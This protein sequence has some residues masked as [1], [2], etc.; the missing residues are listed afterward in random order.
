MVV[1]INALNLCYF[2]YYK[3]VPGYVKY[4]NEV[5]SN[6]DNF[7]YQTL[8]SAL[9]ILQEKPR[10]VLFSRL[11]RMEYFYKENRNVPGF[12]VIKDN[13]IR[14]MGFIFTKYSPLTPL[15]LQYGLQNI[16]SGVYDKIASSWLG[17]GIP[18]SIKT[19]PIIS[20]GQWFLK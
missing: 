9:E 7:R 12:K 10:T 19:Y 4:W 1:R 16:N 17:N 2:C 5:K 20:L 18:P 8:T 3:G 14:S 6:P 15:F 11:N 13:S